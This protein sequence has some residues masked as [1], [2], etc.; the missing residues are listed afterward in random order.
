MRFR[1]GMLVEVRF[2]DHSQNSEEALEFVVW[3][4]VCKVER[5]HIVV[6]TWAHPD[7]LS[8]DNQTEFYDIIRA[9]IISACE[10]VEK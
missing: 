1:K 4:R 6:Q 8:N 3:G 2:L 5:K 10:L 7:N 9:C